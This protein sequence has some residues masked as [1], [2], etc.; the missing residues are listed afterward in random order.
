L[1][2]IISDGGDYHTSD[3]AARLSVSPEQVDRQITE[4]RRIGVE[5]HSEKDTGWRL[6]QAI[7]LLDGGRIEAEWPASLRARIASCRVADEVGSTNE[8]LFGLGAPPP[9]DLQI[10]L[11]EYQN[12]GRGR[13]GRQWLSPPASG[14]CL[15]LGM[16]IGKKPPHL[17]AL[18][19]ALGVATKRALA[20]FEI[21]DIGLKWPNDLVADGKLGGI[22]VELRS[23]TEGGF[24]LVAGLGLNIR[25]PLAT[26]ADGN[27]ELN[28]TDLAR[29][30][31]ADL[32]ARSELAGQII[33]H[34]V[35]AAD[36]FMIRGLAP[37]LSELR[38][39][40]TCNGREAILISDAER[41]HGRCCGIA[42]DGRLLF[43]SGGKI[44][45][46][47]AGDISLRPA[48]DQMSSRGVA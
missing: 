33:S 25:L 17:A 42:D 32:P 5:I 9:A 48:G 10:M 16:T 13:R 36:E 22:L 18:P 21:T 23:R 37:F 24:H 6:D 8:E 43:E 11:A 4:L 34:W 12:A 1:L 39:A 28:Y 31:G 46:I 38:K 27:D 47:V 19:L 30:C 41:I 40:D 15:S 29:L 3:L 44:R 7:D 14:L 26:L 2:G 45:K 35:A 20:K